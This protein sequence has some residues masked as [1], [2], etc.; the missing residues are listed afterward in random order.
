MNTITNV[1]GLQVSPNIAKHHLKNVVFRPMVFSATMIKALL[2]GRK[3][4]TRRIINKNYQTNKVKPA[5]PSFTNET[6]CREFKLG[7]EFDEDYIYKIPVSQCDFIWV[8]ETFSEFGKG[9]IYKSDYLA[10]FSDLKIKWKPSLFMPRS[11]CRIFLE[12]TDIRIERLNEISEADAINEGIE[13]S[14][15]KS[16][17]FKT[18][19]G[20][21]NYYVQDAE[22]EL[23]YKSPIDSYKSLCMTINGSES[24]QENPFVFVY[25]F[26]VVECPNGFI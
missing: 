11:A 8:R 25:T 26:K 6:D 15:V 1:E 4:Q 12:V 17:I 2:D 19:L 21:K 10:E 16:S 18:Y 20:F 9:F 23:Y 5:K 22:D 7:N 24:W 13:A 3:T 14:I